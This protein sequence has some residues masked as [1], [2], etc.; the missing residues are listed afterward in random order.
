MF[1]LGSASILPV[2][3][4]IAGDAEYCAE[5][6]K[7]VGTAYA[8]PLLPFPPPGRVR[9][10]KA[11]SFFDPQARADRAEPGRNYLRQSPRTLPSSPRECPLAPIQGTV[12][13]AG[14]SKEEDAAGELAV[15]EHVERSIERCSRSV[16]EFS[17]GKGRTSEVETRGSAPDHAAL[18]SQANSVRRWEVRF[19]RAQRNICS[20]RGINYHPARRRTWNPGGFPCA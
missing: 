12:L 11:D 1:V 4:L 16:T 15:F 18:D 13:W 8:L 10:L 17:L 6:A 9:L 2:T 14:G 19:S 5:T 20:L 3:R 7:C